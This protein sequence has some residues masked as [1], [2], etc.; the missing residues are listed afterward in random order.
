MTTMGQTTPG[1]WGRVRD[2]ARSLY[3]Y[4][5]RLNQH[6]QWVYQYGA[7]LGL[8]DTFWGRVRLLLH[9]WDKYRPIRYYI[10]ARYFNDRYSSVRVVMA[11]RRESFLHVRSQQH[12]WQYWVIDDI[13]SFEGTITACHKIPDRDCLEMVA[14]WLAMSREKGTNVRAWF[15][16]QKQ[17]GKLY[18]EA[19]TDQQV[20]RILHNPPQV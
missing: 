7:A 8:A 3:R 11:F 6:R 16:E 12:H 9:D 20:Q 5:G 2:I 19:Q 17:N 14:D 13:T 1:W 10:Y 15:T 18:L 4:W